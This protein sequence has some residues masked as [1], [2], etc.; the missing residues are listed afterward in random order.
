[1][2]DAAVVLIA[3]DGDEIDTSDSD[4]LEPMVEATGRH[5]ELTRP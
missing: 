2:I 5:L 3:N 1:V 4:D